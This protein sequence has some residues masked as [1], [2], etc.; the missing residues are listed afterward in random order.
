MSGRRWSARERIPPRAELIEQAAE[1]SRAG[2][3]TRRERIISTA[4]PI[5]QTSV[6][7]ALAWLNGDNA[8]VV[9]QLVKEL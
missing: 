1:A 7:S 2:I 6:A 5:L 8:F 3:R 4:R 9:H